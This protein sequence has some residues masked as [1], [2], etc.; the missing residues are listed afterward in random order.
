MMLLEVAP[1]NTTTLTP[2]A[3]AAATKVTR[4]EENTVATC[5]SAIVIHIGDVEDEDDNVDETVV[6]SIKEMQTAATAKATE[7]AATCSKEEARTCSQEKEEKNHD[8]APTTKKMQQQQQP[9]QLQAIDKVLH[10]TTKTRHG[11]VLLQ[12]QYRGANARKRHAQ[13]RAAAADRP[14]ST[15]SNSA[16]SSLS[17]ENSSSFPSQLSFPMA[18][19]RFRVLLKDSQT[20]AMCEMYPPD[21]AQYMMSVLFAPLLNDLCSDCDVFTLPY[22]TG[23]TNIYFR[24][25]ALERLEDLRQQYFGGRAASKIQRAWRRWKSRQRECRGGGVAERQRQDEAS[26]TTMLTSTARMYAHCG[27]GYVRLVRATIIVQRWIRRRKL[28]KSNKNP[29]QNLRVGSTTVAA[30]SIQIVQEQDAQVGG[31]THDEEGAR[32]PSTVTGLTS[33]GLEAICTT[34]DDTS[35]GNLLATSC[36]S[37]QSLLDNRPETVAAANKEPMQGCLETAEASS[38]FNTLALQQSSVSKPGEKGEE[39]E[40][41]NRVS[42]IKDDVQNE[43]H[44]QNK[45]T[46][47]A[48]KCSS[49]NRE[50]LEAQ[51]RRLQKELECRNKQ[52]AD[53]HQ[54]LA[55]AA[56]EAEIHTQQIEAEYEDRL[57]AY[58]EEVLQL[59]QERHENQENHKAKIEQQMRDSCQQSLDYKNHVRCFIFGALLGL[60]SPF[61]LTWHFAF[62]FFSPLLLQLLSVSMQMEEIVQAR[63]V[64]T[65]EILQ[66]FQALQSEKNAKILYLEAQLSQVRNSSRTMIPP[67][68]TVASPGTTTTDESGGWSST[69]S[70][71]THEQ[72]QDPAAAAASPGVIRDD[73]KGGG[74]NNNNSSYLDEVEQLRREL[75]TITSSHNVAELVEKASCRPWQKDVHIQRLGKSVE[76]RVNKLCDLAMQRYYMWSSSSCEDDGESTTTTVKQHTAVHH[77]VEEKDVLLSRSYC[78]SPSSHVNVVVGRLLCSPGTTSL[79]S[80]DVDDS[81][82]S[83]YENINRTGK[84]Q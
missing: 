39:G 40:E 5:S 70:S 82:S 3:A 81:S 56:E 59:K 64:E 13:A 41:A 47:D 16:A 76:A 9:Q 51:I 17:R 67:A 61:F 6:G 77:H 28:L 20:R 72:E 33:G 18:E 29:Q 71:S 1:P 58:E 53:L 83:H 50:S 74:C 21:R 37:Q 49:S 55:N 14:L 10:R 35:S 22:T 57:A 69:S 52:V 25:G 54:E 42:T 12:A 19:D 23:K 79:S 68:L 34:H 32:E 38:T 8:A 63:K 2:D 80:L 7:A 36:I 60:L 44:M 78:S 30:K 43:S 84:S 24:A 48:H 15:R 65:E 66:Q 46:D 11:F 45:S 73:G 31:E 62:I 27:A 26:C 75:L 4:D